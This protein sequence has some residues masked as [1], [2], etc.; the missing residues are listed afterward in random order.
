MAEGCCPWNPGECGSVKEY[1]PYFVCQPT[2]FWGCTASDRWKLRAFRAERVLS[3]LHNAILRD[4]A[5]EMLCAMRDV[6]DYFERPNVPKYDRIEIV[7][8]SRLA[9]ARFDIY[10]EAY[11]YQR[12]REQIAKALRK[13]ADIVER[14]PQKLMREYYD[15]GDLWPLLKRG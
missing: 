6:D 13:L 14:E 4:Q 7:V 3:T 8:D 1:P 15:D 9:S 2:V 5:I 11:P 10:R 12:H